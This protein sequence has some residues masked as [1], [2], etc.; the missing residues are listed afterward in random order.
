MICVHVDN[1]YELDEIKYHFSNI[2]DLLLFI[3]KHV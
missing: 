1:M 3:L 2:T